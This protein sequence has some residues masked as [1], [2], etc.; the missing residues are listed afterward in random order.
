MSNVSEIE[1]STQMY[2]HIP[3]IGI[4]GSFI[5]ILP[6]IRVR[7]EI[8]AKYIQTDLNFLLQMSLTRQLVQVF[9]IYL[10]IH[11]FDAN[12]SN[13]VA[14]SFFIKKDGGQTSKNLILCT[15]KMLFYLYLLSCMKGT[16]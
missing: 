5:G 9:C 12:I 11:K 14:K 10:I 3:G 1:Q 16:I 13:C 8:L 7:L 15:S 6:H 2:P 4:T